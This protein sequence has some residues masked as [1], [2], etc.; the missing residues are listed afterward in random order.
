MARK[1][2]YTSLDFTAPVSRSPRLLL[3]TSTVIVQLDSRGARTRRSNSVF[4]RQRNGVA[5]RRFNTVHTKKQRKQIKIF[6]SSLII[7]VS[8]KTK[9][10]WKF[11]FFLRTSVVPMLSSDSEWNNFLNNNN[12][13]NSVLLLKWHFVSRAADENGASRE[14][15]SLRGNRR[16]REERQRRLQRVGRELA[17]ATQRC[18]TSQRGIAQ[19]THTL[20]LLSEWADRS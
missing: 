2:S 12:N 5:H 4:Y 1:S 10:S 18:S 16:E 20:L 9:N 19:H 17:K 8:C 6:L 13:N 14:R 3:V 7:S 15:S 11:I